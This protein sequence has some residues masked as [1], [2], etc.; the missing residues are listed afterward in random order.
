MSHL[1]AA[2][3]LEPRAPLIKFYIREYILEYKL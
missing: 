3:L 2:E 1:L